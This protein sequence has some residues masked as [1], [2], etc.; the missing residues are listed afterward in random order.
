M[1]GANPVHDVFAI[2]AKTDSQIPVISYAATYPVALILVT[3]VARALISG[4]S[5]SG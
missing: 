2:T 5:L 3:L 4:L 1:S